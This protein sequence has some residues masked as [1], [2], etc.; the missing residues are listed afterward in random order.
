MV[1]VFSFLFMRYLFNAEFDLNIIYFNTFSRLFPFFIGSAAATLWGMNAEQ[2]NKLKKRFF[3]TRIKL[4]TT[5]LI[6][7]TVSAAAVI[8]LVFSQYEFYDDFIYRLGFLLTSLLTV[9]LIY[10]THGLHIL[11]PPE[12]KEPRALTVAAD[13]SYDVYLY[14]WPFYIILSALIMNNTFASLSTI[15]VSLLFSALMVYVVQRIILPQKDKPVRGQEYATPAIITV[16]IIGALVTGGV[17]IARA[18]AI[19]SIEN[20]L[21]VYYENAEIGNKEIKTLFGVRSSATLSR[22]KKIVKA[23]MIKNNIPSFNPN[24][25]N[26][27]TAYEVW[28]IDVNDLEERRNK[29]KELFL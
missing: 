15:A 4:K 10:G 5:A 3:K 9:V 17:V 7:L 22:L 21:K 8:A 6:L 28:G 29:I 2:D 1:A 19:T 12:K 11:T 24:R 13:L 18:P 14:H 26:T 23:E 25:V 20:A 16:L 27:K